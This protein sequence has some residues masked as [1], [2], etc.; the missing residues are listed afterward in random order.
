MLHTT[1]F[2]V[3]HITTRTVTESREEEKKQQDKEMGQRKVIN[4]N[5]V[6]DNILSKWLS[7]DHKINAFASNIKWYNLNYFGFGQAYFYAHIPFI[8]QNDTRSLESQFFMYNLG[9]QL[10]NSINIL[11]DDR[12]NND[13]NS[14]NNDTNSNESN[15]SSDSD[16]DEMTTVNENIHNGEI[17]TKN[18]KLINLRYEQVMIDLKIYCSTSDVLEL[19]TGTNVDTFFD[20]SSKQ[21]SIYTNI[22]RPYFKAR[23]KHLGLTRH[24]LVKNKIC[25][26]VCNAINQLRT[27]MVV[28]N[29]TV[30]QMMQILIHLILVILELKIYFVE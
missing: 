13:S 7:S 20:D 21:S 26:S 8:N 10:D 15:D 3:N 27:Q 9:R 14:T 29:D 28:R 12:N 5:G 1:Q 11:S 19:K 23:N 30:Q 25:D 6:I 24:E 17:D 16:G 22:D 18:G 4:D 2:N